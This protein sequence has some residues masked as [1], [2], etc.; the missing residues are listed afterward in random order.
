MS[1]SSVS[2]ETQTSDDERSATENAAATSVRRSRDTFSNSLTGGVGAEVSP[3]DAD[4]NQILSIVLVLLFLA[5]IG[6]GAYYGFIR[7]KKPTSPFNPL[8][9][10]IK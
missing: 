3:S 4:G 5:A 2:S 1:K 9:P 10:K 8:N 6:V 7:P